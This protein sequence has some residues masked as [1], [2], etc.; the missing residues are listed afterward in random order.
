MILERAQI[1]LVPGSEQEFES[2]LDRA[3][4]VLE[5][6]RGFRSLRVARGIENPSRYLLLIEWE[7]IED[8]MVGFRESDLFVRWRQL[9]GPYFAAPPL[10]EHF[11]EHFAVEGG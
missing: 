4:A 7:T 9:I 5:E 2:A 1:D 10:V 8:H 6:A 3:R 11:A